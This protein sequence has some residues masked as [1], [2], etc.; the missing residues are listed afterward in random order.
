M[1]YTHGKCD[2]RNIVF[3][4]T[5][6]ALALAAATSVA[7]AG[8]RE[9][10]KRIHDRL[11]GTPPSEAT[12]TSMANKIA[13]GNSV[14]A[15]MDAM[16]NPLFYNVTLKNFVTPWTNE[17]STPFADLNDFTATVIGMV[18]DDVPFNQVLTEDIVYIGAGAQSTIPYAQTD[19]EHYRQIESLRIDMS[20]PANLIR[21]TQSSLPGAVLSAAETA[22]VM[23]TRAFGEA[24]LSM[25]TNR[26][27]IRFAFMNFMCRDMEDMHDTTRTP[28]RI[29]QDVSRSPG[30]DS[31]IFLNQCIG[32]HA[33]MDP[34]TQAFTYYDFAEI[35]QDAG[36]QIVITPG[37]VQPKNLINAGNFPPGF[38]VT[39]DR[40]DN[41]WR[42]G[43][44]ASM[45]WSGALPGGGNGVKSLGQEIASSAAFA[46]CQVQK[47]FKQVCVRDPASAADQSEVQRI[48]GVFTANNYSMKRVFAE[49][50]AFCKGE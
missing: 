15:A 31:T 36:E 16:T 48:T 23:T 42:K 34:L 12:L 10:A 43:V 6:L 27:A 50:A 37:I 38:V 45:G 9:Q 13:A 17:N 5:A 29:R 30:G 8:P 11:A 7:V 22:G 4:R 14:G 1:K 25:G 2:S 3:A 26:R 32:C 18:R 19:N 47:V 41:Y 49:T 40:W 39:N 33:G 44:N 24:F 20:N 46:Q 35:T 28:D 21:T